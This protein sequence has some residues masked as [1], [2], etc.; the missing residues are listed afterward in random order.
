MQC[1]VVQSDEIE[2]RLDPYYLK[3]IT[4][5]KA[6]Q[7]KYQ[8]S[9]FNDLLK[10]PPQ[11]GANE[12]AVDGNPKSDVRYIRITDI[13][14]F[15]N[16]KDGDWKTAKNI[17]DKYLLEG[18]DILFARSG[19]TAG[20]TFLYKKEYGQAIFAGYL[21]RFKIEETKANPLYVFY[22]TQLDR[23]AFWVK[24]IQ[25]PSGQPN[26]NSKEFKSF[27]FPLPPL[28]IQ[29]QI[30]DIMRSAYAQ[31]KQMEAEAQKLLDSID[32][33]VLEELGIKLPA[34]EDKMCVVV[35]SE[36][37]QNNRMDAYYYQPKFE[38]VEKALEGGKYRIEK[39][40]EFITKIHYGISIKNVYVDEG[41]PLLR[42]LNLKPNKIDL[43][44]VVNL[45]ESKRKEIGNGFVYESDLLISRSGSVGIVGVVPKEADG[46]AFGSFMIKFCINDEISKEYVSLW[47]NNN[48]TKLLTE[49]EKIGAIQGNITISTIEN[50]QIPLPPLEIQNKI[51]AEV[52]RRISEAERLKTEASKIIEEAKKQVEEMILGD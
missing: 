32:S 13:D 44:D 9:K 11:Y 21:I 26:I 42:I 51:A 46:F 28:F 15:G 17:D 29:D 48:F 22:F 8:L 34:V 39:L 49:R 3:N 19:A 50:F 18:N 16:L 20:K 47:L 37:V 5:I 43:R 35:D 40:K 12:Q 4:V 33:Y 36:E 2:G 30:V 41:I 52:K 45:E 23:Y 24:S 10:E 31:K 6:T 25:R 38:E 7:T 27:K 14:E 1:F